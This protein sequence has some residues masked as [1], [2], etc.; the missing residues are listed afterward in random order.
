M[1]DKHAFPSMGEF[2]LTKREWFAGQAL[3]GLAANTLISKGFVELAKSDDDAFAVFAR[4]SFA[5]ADA[6]IAES[7]RTG[8]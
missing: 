6:M 2:G 7:E 8:K 1:N 4:D 3:A 5:I